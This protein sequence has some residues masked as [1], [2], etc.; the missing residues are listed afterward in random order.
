MRYWV[1]RIEVVVPHFSI[2]IFCYFLLQLNR[3]KTIILGHFVKFSWDWLIDWWLLYNINLQN[4]TFI[5]LLGKSYRIEV[6]DT[7]WASNWYP[8]KQGCFL[9]KL[10][11]LQCKTFNF[12]SVLLYSVIAILDVVPAL[13]WRNIC[14]C[15]SLPDF[16]SFL[17]CCGRNAWWNSTDIMITGSWNPFQFWGTDTEI[18]DS[19]FFQVSNRLDWGQAHLFLLHQ[20]D[21]LIAR[22][23]SSCGLSLTSTSITCSP[24]GV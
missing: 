23:W 10:S 20:D 22:C 16:C 11:N 17:H 7:F 21:L 19:R 3:P 14:F 4:R 6:T 5:D 13:I 2:S 1:S 18:L 9:P 24:G 12:N 15:H 8:G